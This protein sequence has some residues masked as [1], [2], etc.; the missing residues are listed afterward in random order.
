MAGKSGWAKRKI[1]QQLQEEANGG[2]SAY[3]HMEG[4]P[5]NL[6]IRYDV[7]SAK[8]ILSK[9]I[10]TETKRFFDN[11]TKELKGETLTTPKKKV[12]WDE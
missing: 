9:E 1:E 4:T 3:I 8:E 12:K 7:K 11:V 10:K 2:M 5:D 6:K